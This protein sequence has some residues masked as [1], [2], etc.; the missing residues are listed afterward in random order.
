M[1]IAFELAPLA[2][3][4]A[5][6]FAGGIYWATGSLMLV[7]VAVAVVHRLRHGSFKKQHV[8]TAVVVLALGGATLVL[9]DKRFIQLKP[10]VLFAAFALAL[11]LSAVAARKTLLQRI[12]EA[13]APDTF[14]LPRAT[15]QTLNGVWIAWFTAAAAANW[16]V[17]QN[18][19]EN[20]WVQFHTYGLGVANIVFMLPQIFWIAA[21]NRR[22]EPASNVKS[23]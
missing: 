23:P 7:T 3:F 6:Y 1:N 11:A 15:W 12:F 21:K 18:F 17:A 2:A 13:I 19:S 14:D 16:Y 20:F 9:K 5:A 8:V 10:T 22:A 4:L